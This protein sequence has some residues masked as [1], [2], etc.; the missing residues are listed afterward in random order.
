VKTI[1]TGIQ[2][3]GSIHIGNYFGS[4]KPFFDQLKDED[5]QGFLFV[6]DL[7]AMTTG[8]SPTLRQDSLDTAKLLLAIAKAEKVDL[9]RLHLFIQSE[10]R[11]HLEMAYYLS[12][13]VSLAQLTGMIQF[14][15][16]SQNYSPSVALATY[17]ILMAADILLYSP[18]LIPVGKDQAEHLE[19]TQKLARKFNLKP[20]KSLDKQSIKI[21]SLTDGTKKMSKSDTSEKSRINLLDSPEKIAHKISKAKSGV[22]LT[23]QTPE[24]ENL[25]QIYRLLTQQDVDESL[26]L[27]A[28]KEAL[29]ESLV[30][31]LSAI[32]EQFEGITFTE[33]NDTLDAGLSRATQAS[34][35]TLAKIV[36]R[37]HENINKQN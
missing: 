29:S 37:K 13:Q 16:K 12:T 19:L 30:K 26:Q 22:T 6:A 8:Y 36:R 4:I 9:N 21:M 27:S 34:N 33:L 20:I 23:D 35:I 24:L 10:N 3:T 5:T 2:P 25:K 1:L 7:H 14:K 28:F 18:E 15:E 32:R 11:D 17:P 31:E